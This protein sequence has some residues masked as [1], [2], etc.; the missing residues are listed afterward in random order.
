MMGFEQTEL[1][2]KKWKMVKKISIVSW[3]MKS[4]NTVVKLQQ[5]H[6]LRDQ[7][8]NFKKYQRKIPGF[9]DPHWPEQ[10]GRQ[11]WKSWVAPTR[12]RTQHSRQSGSW[13]WVVE[14]MFVKYIAMMSVSATEFYFFVFKVQRKLVLKY[15]HIDST[16]L[17]SGTL[18]NLKNWIKCNAM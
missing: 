6:R 18:L 14:E 10:R 9:L 16:E 13:W 3:K 8:H 12:R 17:E 15:F 11:C 2:A 7:H 5:L 1:M 4:I